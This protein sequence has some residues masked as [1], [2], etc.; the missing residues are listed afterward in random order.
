VISKT[1]AAGEEPITEGEVESGV[2]LPDTDNITAG[3]GQMYDLLGASQVENVEFALENPRYSNSP[4]GQV[5]VSGY[6]T[7]IFNAVFYPDT[8]EILVPSV[9][10]HFI[11]DLKCNLP[12]NG[13]DASNLDNGQ[14]YTYD[15]DS[16]L[17]AVFWTFIFQAPSPSGEQEESI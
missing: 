2:W 1:A 12:P 7:N 11:F 3:A 14:S 17:E 5:P 10:E 6:P 13:L 4:S 16:T 8:K 9:P 15:L